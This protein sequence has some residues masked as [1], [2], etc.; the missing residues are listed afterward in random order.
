MGGSGGGYFPVNVA[1]DDLA[2]RTRLAESRVRDDAFETNI[3]DFLASLLSGFNERN[4]EGIQKVF[5]QIKTDLAGEIEGTIDTLFGGS[6][7]K[8]TYVDGISDVDALVTLSG[9]SLADMSPE[10]IKATLATLLRDR[11]G[12]RAVKV[13]TLAVTVKLMGLEIQ[14]LPALRDGKGLK[15]ASA[16]G[17]DWSRVNPGR[18]AD[19]LTKANRRLGGKLVPCIK[20]IKAIVAALPE[21]RRV[22]GYHAEAMAL[23]VFGSYRGART[24]KAMLS[25]FFEHAGG[26]VKT[27]IRDRSGQSTHVDEYLGADGS[28]RR[29]VV[30]DALGR[31]GRRIRNADGARSRE[32]WEK[33]FE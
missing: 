20:L 31:V 29:R 23:Q 22:T 16:V 3:G 1:P 27:A 32:L 6:V 30:A 24:T 4:V 12:N 2:R 8:H 17:S 10:E 14:V 28:L 7:A 9:S 15:I 13:G 19:A 26:R 18:F 33:L 11:Y 21:G 25:Y 5:N